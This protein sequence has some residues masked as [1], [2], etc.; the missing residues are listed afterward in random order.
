[1]LSDAAV[2]VAGIA[3]AMIA[4]PV[5]VTLAAVWFGDASTVARRGRS[6]ASA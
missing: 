1:M 2:H 6:M 5:L 4:V 3:G